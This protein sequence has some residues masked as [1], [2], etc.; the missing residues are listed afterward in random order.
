MSRPKPENII[1]GVMKLSFTC[2]K[3]VRCFK[4]NDIVH[5]SEQVDPSSDIDVMK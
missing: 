1:F 5:V 4:D 3:L 2:V